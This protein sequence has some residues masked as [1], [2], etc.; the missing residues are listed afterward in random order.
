[1]KKILLAILL[2]IAS[3]SQAQLLDGLEAYW[4]LDEASGNAIDAHGSSDLT[5]NNTV[6][7][8]TGIIN[9]GRSTTAANSEKLSIADN[10]A[11]SF[12]DESFTVSF[13][14]Q[15]SDLT[16]ANILGKWDAASSTDHEWVIQR[17]SNNIRLR[18]SNNGTAVTGEVRGTDVAGIGALSHVVCYHDADANEVGVI[19]NDG[20]PTTASY[21]G[22]VRD[23]THAFEIGGSDSS[24]ISIVA[25]DEVGVWRRKLTSA[26]ITALYNS[27][28]GLSYDSFT[29]SSTGN[30]L[31]LQL[32]LGQ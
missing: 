8:T 7:A 26:E 25:I 2:S 31:L 16:T 12:G 27:G 15:T 30:P 29:A 6:P 9:N 5:D 4:K 19:I 3:T 10:A 21:S 32:L 20:T 23:G 11:L 17:I 18:V 28:S 22:G 1:M 14:W 24:Y 13:W